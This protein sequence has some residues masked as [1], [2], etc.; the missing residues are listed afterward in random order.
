[1]RAMQSSGM[2]T[3]RTPEKMS[4]NAH[5]LAITTATEDTE[6]TSWR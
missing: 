4:G 3:M 2:K 5:N 1:M 6:N